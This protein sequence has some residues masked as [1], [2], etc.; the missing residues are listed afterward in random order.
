MAVKREKLMKSSR[1]FL[2]SA[3]TLVMGLTVF[4]A[5][6][7]EGFGCCSPVTL[8]SNAVS[9]FSVQGTQELANASCCSSGTPSCCCATTASP[10]M[11]IVAISGC[12]MQSIF[13]PQRTAEITRLPDLASRTF[14]TLEPTAYKSLSALR[15]GGQNKEP[16]YILHRQL[17]I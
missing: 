13:I 8:E 1:Q 5:T 17:L 6:T 7:R 14:N 16:I 15:A 10:G 12:Q 2:R 3:L 9:V 11:G 4:L